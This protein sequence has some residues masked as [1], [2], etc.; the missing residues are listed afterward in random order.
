[1]YSFGT[2]FV[3]YLNCICITFEL[4]L[5]YCLCI[6]FLAYLYYLDCI[7][8]CAWYFWCIC[9]GTK[10]PTATAPTWCGPGRGLGRRSLLSHFSIIDCHRHRHRHHYHHHHHHDHDHHLHLAQH[11]IHHLLTHW[12]D[13]FQQNQFLWF[14]WCMLLVRPCQLGCEISQGTK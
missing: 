5:Y 11:H 12:I 2:I 4:A 8:V 3:L 10:T 9:I 7:V 6:V 13:L 14:R 1:M